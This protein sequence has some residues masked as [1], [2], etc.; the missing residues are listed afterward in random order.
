MPAAP[1]IQEKVSEQSVKWVYTRPLTFAGFLDLYG[2][3]DFVE[4]IDGVV[5]ERPIAV[6][7]L[8]VLGGLRIETDWLF[9]EPRPDER[10]IVDTWLGARHA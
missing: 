6:L 5:V 8:Q 3:K 4:L 2:P 10:E 7:G 9:E 1:G